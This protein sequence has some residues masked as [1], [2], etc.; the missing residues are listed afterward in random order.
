MGDGELVLENS[1]IHKYLQD[2]GWNDTST[3][4][5]T[6]QIPLKSKGSTIV[7]RLQDIVKKFS[8]TTSSTRYLMKLMRGTYTK[9]S[10]TDLKILRDQII[11]HLL[12]PHKMHVLELK[13]TNV[14]A[15]YHPFISFASL[16][17]VLL[18]SFVSQNMYCYIG[19]SIISI[20]GSVFIFHGYK[21][22]KDH[23]NFT[24]RCYSKQMRRLKQGSRVL[25][26]YLR[27]CQVGKM[28]MY[29]WH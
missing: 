21:T 3:F 1:P 16:A 5:R 27:D 20:F 26:S 28:I 17:I 19:C 8:N 25:L 24:I 15:T 12:E 9:Y 10:D 14:D 23:L 18:L 11:P 4:T 22:S 6:N 13:A 2:I 7:S 29:T